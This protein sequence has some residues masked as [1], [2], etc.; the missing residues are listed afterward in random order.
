MKKFRL[1]FLVVAVSLAAAACKT[2]FFIKKEAE[3]TGPQ[4]AAPILQQANVAIGGRYDVQGS[5]PS[6]QGGGYTG[7]VDITQKGDVYYLYWHVGNTYGGLGIRDGNT[8]AVS[9][10][11][12]NL[13]IF[14]VVSYKIQPDGSLNGVWAIA[15]STGLGSELLTPKR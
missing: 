1:G 12:A 14:G 10:A 5:N 2:S 4:A 11:N 3:V 13:G 6:G 9:W 7:T 15:D 8:L